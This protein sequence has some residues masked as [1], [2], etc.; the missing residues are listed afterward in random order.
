MNAVAHSMVMKYSQKTVSKINFKS[1]DIE[2]RR[3]NYV[4]LT[5]SFENVVAVVVFQGTVAG[6]ALPELIRKCMNKMFMVKTRK[7]QIN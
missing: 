1:S 7:K 4:C 2:E 5:D 3:Q 6:G